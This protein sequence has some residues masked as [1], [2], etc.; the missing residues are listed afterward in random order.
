MKCK[1]L[2]IVLI[3]FLF[4]STGTAEAQIY[5]F[6]G[7]YAVSD[8]PSWFDNPP[9]YSAREA[10]ALV[11]G[12][13]P[14]DYAISILP[15]LDPASITFS[16]YYDCWGEGWSEYSQDY[17]LDSDPAGYKFPGGPGTAR[18]A[19]VRDHINYA[20]KNY[21]WN[22]SYDPGSIIPEP[23]TLIL[24]SSGF[25]GMGLFGWLRRRR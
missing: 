8:G 16:G 22:V 24:L 17:K 19:Y 23:A 3:F 5:T 20:F 13:D 2:I 10:A 7:F 9:V 21:V 4:I 15:N 25:L 14:T 18:S 6:L 1:I 11:F 12:S